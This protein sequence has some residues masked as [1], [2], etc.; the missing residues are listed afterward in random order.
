MEF[1]VQ[2]LDRSID[3]LKKLFT[4]TTQG[5]IFLDW[6]GQILAFNPMA[7]TILEVSELETLNRHFLHFFRDDYLGFS[8]QKM[9]TIRKPPSEKLYARIVLPSKTEKDLET[10]VFKNDDG[11]IILFS[12]ITEFRKLQVE[13]TRNTRMKELGGMAAKLAHEIRNPLGGIKGYASLLH[14]DLKDQPNLQQMTGYI[15]EGA[16]HLNQLVAH[17]LNYAHPFQLKMESADLITLIAEL[18]EYIKGDEH[19]SDNIQMQIITSESQCRL[20]LDV[21]VIRSALLNLFVNAMQAMPEGGLLTIE[22]QQQPSEVMIRIIDTGIGMAPEN[23]KKAFNSF[24]TTKVNGNGFGLL[25]V[26]K[27]I[28]AHRGTIEISSIVNEGTTFTIK[29]PLKEVNR[30]LE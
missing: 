5:V 4:N 1:Q 19:Y 30:P 3:F 15:I 27:A 2:Q 9:L 6:N 28:Q 14:R 17:V 25:E 8:L 18:E 21:S 26:Y 22:I 16:D 7:V 11:L 10:Q 23:V 13:T 24:F 29:L 12:N 20:P